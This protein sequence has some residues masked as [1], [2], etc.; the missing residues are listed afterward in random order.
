MSFQGVAMAADSPTGYN[1]KDLPTAGCF[2]TGPFSASNPKTNVAYPGT[3]ITYW[4]AK[5]ATPPGA[6]LTLKGSYPHARYSSF[7]AYEAGGVSASSLN[8][9]Q[10]KPNAGSINPS[11]P[12][13]NRSARNRS[14]EIKVRGEAK[15]SQTARNT[16]YAAPI[17]GSHQD[18]LYRVYVPDRGRSLSGGTG[19]PKPVLTL[20][21]GRRLEGQALCDELNSIHE[22]GSN[23]MPNAIYQSLVHTAGKDP[24]TN[25]A[26]PGFQFRKF[27]NLPNAF[28]AYGTPEDQ[29]AAWARNPVEEG[30]QYNNNDARYMTGAYSFKFG[31]VLALRG[32]MPTTPKTLN[33]QKKM[34][35]GQLVEWDMC[36]IQALTTTKTYR[37]RFDEQIPV[38]GKKRKY[39]IAFA[40]AGLRPKN[41]KRECDV[42]WLPAD[43]EGDGAGRT[44]V[45]LLLTRNVLPSQSFHKSIFDVS[46]PFNAEESMGDYYP[47]GDY[48]S[49]K[50]FESHGCPYK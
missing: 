45:G 34:K 24:E 13:K 48:T 42:A 35:S 10:I 20:A 3:E 38:K 50:A 12:G 5:F 17:E 29:Q 7:N 1:P 43:P 23:L 22:Y 41:A 28:S 9:S 18:I 14:Y 15:P 39:V 26:L 6:V 37:C 27:F 4:G 8:D 21:D 16:L 47:K 25:P 31:E 30:T 11:R 33:G 49:K 36:G 40:K 44:D 19:V 2:W 32:R 46:S